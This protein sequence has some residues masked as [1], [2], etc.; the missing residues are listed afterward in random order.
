MR[1]ANIAVTNP[2]PA[3]APVVIPKARARGRATIPTVIPAT[4]SELQDFRKFR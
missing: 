2:A 3:P 1:P 4:K